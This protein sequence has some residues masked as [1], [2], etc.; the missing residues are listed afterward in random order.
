MK[1]GEELEHPWL[2]RS[3]ES[4]QKKV[5]QHLFFARSVS[6]L[7]AFD[8]AVEILEGARALGIAQV[9]ITK[10]RAARW[11]Q[12]AQ[13]AA[14]FVTVAWV[15]YAAIYVLSLPGSAQ[16]MIS[17]PLTLGGIVASILAP[18]AMIWLCLSTW[19]RRNDAIN[20]AREMRAELR[21][22]ILPG[23]AGSQ[24]LSADLQTLIKQA[25]EISATSRASVKAIQRARMALREEIQEL[26]TV[27]NHTETQLDRLSEIGRAHV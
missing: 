13:Y 24:L 22:L 2:N 11:L 19:Q 21:N 3:I 7:G 10:N 16:N 26:G 18:V 27:S 4:A 5:E 14:V 9:G 20:Y 1:E 8:L 15:S 17:S 25:M 12:T 23:D 6:Q